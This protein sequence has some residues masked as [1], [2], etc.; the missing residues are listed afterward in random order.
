MA[1]MTSGPR[2]LI[3]DLVRGRGPD[4]QVDIA[5]NTSDIARH[6]VLKSHQQNYQG[7]MP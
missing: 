4:L 1:K 7:H 3:L 5:Y 2:L 6:N